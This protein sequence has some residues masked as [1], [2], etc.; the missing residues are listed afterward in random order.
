MHK[1]TNILLNN[2]IRF[3]QL[4]EYIVHFIEKVLIKSTCI[5]NYNTA[6]K[7]VSN[8]Q[9]FSFKTNSQ[10]LTFINTFWLIFIFPYFI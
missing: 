1:T 8:K 2:N 10:I 7:I 4:M 5:S 3:Q 6:Y 9:G